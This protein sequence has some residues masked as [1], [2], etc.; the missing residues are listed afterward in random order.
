VLNVTDR[1]DRARRV[2]VLLTAKNANRTVVKLEDLLAG[3]WDS[4]TI[5]AVQI[6]GGA[7]VVPFAQQPN[8]QFR[9]AKQ[10]IPTKHL[11]RF[12]V[13]C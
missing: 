8:L 1:R 2:A 4:T 10:L 11:S 13:N 6:S 12:V 9:L 7:R 3:E 5:G